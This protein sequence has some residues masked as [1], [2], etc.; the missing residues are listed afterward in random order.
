[1]VNVHRQKSQSHKI[2]SASVTG[3]IKIW[4]VCDCMWTLFT[5]PVFLLLA[6]RPN[7]ATSSQSSPSVHNH[8]PTD[9]HA[10][11][12]SFESTNRLKPSIY[13]PI[14]I[15]PSQAS[16]CTTTLP[17]MPG[18]HVNYMNARVRLGS[19]LAVSVSIWQRVQTSTQLHGLCVCCRGSIHVT[20]YLNCW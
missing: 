5:V 4:D 16:P 15:S 17:C 2:V 7:T 19:S 13:L 10:N 6:S 1:M 18:K 20:I 9:P 8:H 12:A 14:P 11:A 3:K